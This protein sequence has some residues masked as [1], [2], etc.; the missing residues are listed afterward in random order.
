[1]KT[2]MNFLTLVTFLVALFAFSAVGLAA[3]PPGAGNGGG[4]GGGGGGNAPPDYGD[5]III[6]R[7]LDGV[8]IPSD[9]TLVED[10]ETGEWVAGGLCW[11]PLA[12][13]SETCELFEIVNGEWYCTENKVDPDCED[14][15]DEICE[16]QGPCL[17]LVDQYTCGV[18]N[19]GCTQEVDF[20]RMNEARSP[21]DVFQAQLE[22]VVIKLTTADCVT[23]DPA[24]RLVASTVAADDTVS[25]STIDS[26]LQNLAIYRQ[27]MLTGT[28]GFTLPGNPYDTAARGLGAAS[29]KAGE[30]NVDMLAYLNSI[31][32]LSDLATPTVLDKICIDMR[33]EVKGV[34]QLVEKCFLN[35]ADYA[36]DRTENFG[37]LPYPAYIPANDPTDGWFEYM[38]LISEEPPT[39]GIAY[40]PIM[41]AVFDDLPGFMG[42]NIGG[43]AQAA[44][45]ARAV[46]DFMHNNAVSDDFVTPVHC[47][48]SGDINYDVS[49]SEKSGLQVPKNVVDGSSDREFIVTV[50]NA[51]PDAAEVTLTV[52]AVPVIA[53]EVLADLDGGGFIES[54]FV[55]P[56]IPIPPGGN[57][58]FSA[59]ISV[60]IGQKTTI[61]WTANAATDFDVNTANNYVEATSNVKVTGGGR[62]R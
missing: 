4:G 7:D 39:F 41:G 53:G 5:L 23:L 45:D 24:G 61:N 34:I 35:Y 36:Y 49:I 48:A 2:K 52:T 9:A 15:E 28:L 33:E 19:P 59:L 11:Q 18:L 55:F 56:T 60:A 58:A 14:T 22:D 40:G 43:F 42:G 1:M 31:M 12:F 29:D 27:L 8:P 37:A 54:P 57:H 47:E 51:G 10:P 50:A 25:T 46:I 6:L 3:P 26:P 20:G 30:F 17:V 44:D 62:R 32:G 38:D 16:R 21:D 13:P